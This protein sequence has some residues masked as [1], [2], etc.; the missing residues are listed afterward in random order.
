MTTYRIEQHLDELLSEAFTLA[1]ALDCATPA[2]LRPTADARHGD[3]QCNGAMALAK[4]LQEKPRDIAE[5]VVSTL[6][7]LEPIAR[8]E[9]AGPGFI[10]LTLDPVW[11]AQRVEALLADDNDGVPR[12][13]KPRKVVVD[14]SSPNIAK[15]MHVGHIRSTII[16]DAIIRLLRKVGH[17][18]IGDNHIGDWGTQYGLLIVGMRTFG[19][20]KALEEDA[21]NE[22]ERVY[23]LAT[24]KAKEDDSFA[25]AARAELA[26]LQQGDAENFAMWERFVAA[27]RVKLDEVYALLGVTFDV[28]LGESAYH[29]KLLGV[30]EDL[31]A[32]GIAVEDQGAV[33]V[34]FNR[35]DGAPKDLKARKEPYII[36]KKDG[37][38]L[39]ATSDI[40]TINHRRDA[41]HA[42]HAIYVV[43][44][45][46]SFHF[47][48]LFALA[49]LLGHDMRLEHISFGAVLGADGKPLKTRDGKVITLV[50]LLDEAMSRAEARITEDDSVRIPPEDL[51]EARRAVG[52]GAVK[53]ADLQQNR[54]SDYQFD[55]DKMTSFSGKSGPYLQYAYA[56]TRAIFRKNGAVAEPAPVLLEAPSE[57]ALGK[58]L[59]RFGDVVH[60]AAEDC[61]PH[62]LCDH[63][64]ELARVFSGF[65]AACPVLKSEGE[66]R[67]SRLAL[68]LATSRQLKAGLSLLGIDVLERM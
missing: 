21:I 2:I 67:A 19:D 15:Q 65:Y 11:V 46:Q 7:E 51:P 16:G 4:R 56:R 34:F 1:L 64:Y 14:F 24:A 60:K 53:F 30:V 12:V 9:V 32:S 35:L 55:W 3:Y 18:V 31:L 61:A 37:A 33:C 48:Q 28:W 38:F 6:A 25:D 26:K 49:K 59:A 41:F 50:S 42:D 57:V 5:R 27:T 45:R 13:A 20:E 29:D 58:V 54:V 47:K 8:A 40:A 17:E 52:V 39:Y 23:R 62:H 10:N 63:V 66:T 44:N 36:R 43:D 68:T 22:L